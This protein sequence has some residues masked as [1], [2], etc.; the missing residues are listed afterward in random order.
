MIV[1]VDGL[2][3]RYGKLVAL[4]YLNFEVEEGEIF[5]IRT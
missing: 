5:P 3:K 4:D 1:K 2:V